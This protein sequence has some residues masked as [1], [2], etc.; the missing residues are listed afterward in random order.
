M[1]PE[2]DG[3][4][5]QP[6]SAVRSDGLPN[7][8]HSWLHATKLPATCPTNVGHMSD[9]LPT[10]SRTCAGY[11][12]RALAPPLIVQRGGSVLVSAGALADLTR[13]STLRTFDFSI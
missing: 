2:A 10:S 9:T 5:G 4:T 8:R 12:V 1:P 3:S 6:P 7:A 13:S 11:T